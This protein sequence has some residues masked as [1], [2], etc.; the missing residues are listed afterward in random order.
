[1]LAFWRIFCPGVRKWRW[2]WWLAW[3]SLCGCLA[4]HAQ[5]PVPDGSSAIVGDWLVASRDAIIRIEREGDGYAGRIVW[6]LHDTYGPE[7]G[8]ALA[9]KTVTDRHNP[10]PL[11]RSR[12]LAGLRLLWGLHYDPDGRK[13][14]GGRVYDSDDGKT[15]HCE[16]R[17]LDRD[18][19]SL[20]GYIGVP[21]LGGSTT[22]TR[23]QAPPVT[24]SP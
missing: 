13:W 12:P 20:R 11:L 8:P 10:D 9:G 5:S 23:T 15:Y 16:I 6:Q 17:L 18:R 3:A 22:W 2:G 1:M 21:L 4:L 7:D 24:G 14:V 19:L